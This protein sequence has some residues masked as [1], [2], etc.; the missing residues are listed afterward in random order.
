[1]GFSG[2][3][4]SFLVVFFL[5]STSRADNIFENLRNDQTIPAHCR[6]TQKSFF[7]K[8]PGNIIFGA[9]GSKQR[10]FHHEHRISREGARQLWDL[11]A[12][13]DHFNED[14]FRQAV[15]REPTLSEDLEL[16]RNY[17]PLM[18]F[19]FGSEGEVLE[20]LVLLQLRTMYS[21]EEYYFTGS[22]AYHKPDSDRTIGELDII[23]GRK[24]NCEV[25]VVGETKLGAGSLGK[26]KEQLQRFMKFYSSD[27]RRWRS[28]PDEF[29]FFQ[30]AN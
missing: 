24:S 7:T 13:P 19:D 9:K 22:V 23:I 16:L 27:L 17:G 4:C 15:E 18:G 3:L 20:L 10:G 29:N 12:R 6:E 28:V 11:L 30:W 26:A 14:A 5:A 25:I 1:M 8:P 21:A 2:A